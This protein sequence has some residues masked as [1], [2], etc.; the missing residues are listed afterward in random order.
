MATT[1]ELTSYA[2]AITFS[3]LQP[4]ED[5]GEM[6]LALGELSPIAAVRRM[7]EEAAFELANTTLP[8]D[9]PAGDGTTR[10]RIADLLMVPRMSTFAYG[11]LLNRCVAAMAPGHS[12]VNVGV[13]H[14]FTFLAGCAGN[15]DVTCVGVDDFSEFGGPRTQ[16]LKQFEKR[17]APSHHF[18]EGDY[19][20]YFAE[21]HEGPIG[22]YLYDGGHAYADQLRGLQVAE[23][24]LAD[25]CVIVVDDTNLPE[26]RQATIDFMA[27][28]DR[29]W[30]LV[31]DVR[32]RH[33]MH[34]T[35]WNGV[36]VLRSAA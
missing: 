30:E 21:R 6:V 1:T 19:R 31:F 12:Y 27:T 18:V 4:G 26:P 34:P 8:D 2:D 32:T 28:S 24:F 7:R 15:D 17:R 20:D 33:T 14:G 16:F 36:M 9:P 23:P 11:A 13:W 25:D 10:E 29:S 35:F 3:Q 22:V 5:A